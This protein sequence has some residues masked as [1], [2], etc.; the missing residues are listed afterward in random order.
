MEKPSL[1]DNVRIFA[2]Y[3]LRLFITAGVF[4]CNDRTHKVVWVMKA[5]MLHFLAN[6]AFSI[7]RKRLPQIIHGTMVL[8]TSK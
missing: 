6:V 7:R 5:I 2:Q 3:D 8:I 1:R 4:S